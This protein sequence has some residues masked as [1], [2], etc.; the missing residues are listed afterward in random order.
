MV[1]GRRAARRPAPGPRGLPVTRGRA[2]ASGTPT[3]PPGDDHRL[4]CP[5][6]RDPRRDRDARRSAR[7]P[8]E[9]GGFGRLGRGSTPE[10][11]A[12]GSAAGGARR[13]P[14]AVP[15]ACATMPPRAR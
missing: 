3:V 13:G 10:A 15:P 2:A 12:G 9:R 5:A 1:R 4:T 11:A 7:H 14:R 8:R 6:I